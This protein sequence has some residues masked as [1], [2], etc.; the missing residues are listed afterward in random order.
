MRRQKLTHTDTSEH[1]VF[2]RATSHYEFLATVPRSSSSP[3]GW[4]KKVPLL[5]C[6]QEHLACLPS[7]LKTLLS[8]RSV[9]NCD[10][11]RQVTPEVKARKTVPHLGGVIPRHWSWPGSGGLG[12]R[13]DRFGDPQ[14]TLFMEAAPWPTSRFSLVI[15]IQTYGSDGDAVTSGKSSLLECAFHRGWACG[16]SAV[17]SVTNAP[18]T[19]SLLSEL[20]GIVSISNV[21]THWCVPEALA[22]S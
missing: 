5:S 11:Q 10:R 13:K 21:P 17:S 16:F 15:G 7:S 9:I 12:D 18:D 14:K 22:I 19:R 2:S 4:A 6:N 8:S 3:I 1:E 20:L